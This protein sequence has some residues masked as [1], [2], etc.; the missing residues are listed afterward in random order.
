M[1]FFFD[2]IIFIAC[3]ESHKRLAD[4]LVLRKEGLIPLSR[5]PIYVR[6]HIKYLEH[7]HIIFENDNTLTSC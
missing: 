4:Q 7:V 1:H 2:L 5:K 6:V 3:L